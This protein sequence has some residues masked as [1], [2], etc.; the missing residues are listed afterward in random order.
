MDIMQESS[1][2]IVSDLPCG[3]AAHYHI[4]VT[5]PASAQIPDAREPIKIILSLVSC[6]D[7]M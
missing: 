4:N 2:I 1:G 5:S 6:R 3:F 7:C